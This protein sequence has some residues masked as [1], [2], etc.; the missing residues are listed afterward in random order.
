ML[1]GQVVAVGVSRVGEGRVADDTPVS[2][3]GE[4]FL[5]DEVV[6]RTS[7]DDGVE[8]SHHFGCYN[9]RGRYRG[10]DTVKG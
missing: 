10:V 8:S 6:S 3:N 7:T 5:A 9:Q 4:V 1:E 2:A